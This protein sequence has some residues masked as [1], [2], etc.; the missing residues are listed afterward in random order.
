MK[1][2][3][4]GKRVR[5]YLALYNQLA[6]DFVN[7]DSLG[8]PATPS[9]DAGNVAVLGREEF[10]EDRQAAEHFTGGLEP[11]LRP[12]T[13]ACD[14]GGNPVLHNGFPTGV[15]TKLTVHS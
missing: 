5:A 11:G 12:P 13:I 2:R 8:S 15:F 9:D 7:R 10:L 4:T 14:D 1:S 6:G 3:R